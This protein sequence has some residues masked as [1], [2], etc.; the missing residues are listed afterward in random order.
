ML[1]EDQPLD[2][3]MRKQLP[4]RAHEHHHMN[5]VPAGCSDAED[6]VLNLSNK[7]PKLESVSPALSMKVESPY[8]TPTRSLSRD[9]STSSTTNQLQHYYPLSIP[10]NHHLLQISDPSSKQPNSLMISKLECLEAAA[11]QVDANRIQ[12][13]EIFKYMTQKGLFKNGIQPLLDPTNHRKFS[14]SLLNPALLA[15]ITGVIP[16]NN[17]HPEDS[18][19]KAGSSGSSYNHRSSTPLQTGR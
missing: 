4:P 6:L 10:N 8:T 3:S 13:S 5:H 18:P 11:K 17:H 16:P 19:K 2:L 1:T 7:V 15:Q 12:H 14:P 9:S